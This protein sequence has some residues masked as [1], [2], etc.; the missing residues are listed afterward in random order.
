M[1]IA[2]KRVLLTGATGGLG[3]AIAARFAA[4]GGR[5]LLSARSPDALQR[6]TVQLPGDGHGILPADLSEPGAAERLAADAGEVDVLVANAALPATGRLDELDTEQVARMIRVNL[7]APML[8][9]QSLIP[10]MITRGS[11]KVV[12]VGSLSG[13][14]GSPRGS[15]YSATKFAL[16]GFAFGLSADLAGGPVSVT[17]VAPGF[18]RNAGMFADSGANAPTVL[19]TT[20]PERVASAAL[21]A[22]SSHR[23]EIAVAPFRAR[24]MAHVGLA[25]PTLSNLI[26][27][28][29][30][31][32]KAAAEV[33]AGQVAKR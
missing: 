33:A 28:G 19:G 12:L 20:T 3:R 18:V 11:G 15:V 14:A 24:A 10:G 29:K 21:R 7:E 26:Q 13:K 1:G 31:G 30:A 16:R 17:V 25:S 9:T 23:L 6:L 8:L 22:V 2:G 4:D 27:S 32:Q 5:M